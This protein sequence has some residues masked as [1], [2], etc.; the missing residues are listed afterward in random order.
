MIYTGGDIDDLKASRELIE[1]IYTH[2]PKCTFDFVMITDKHATP[3]DVLVAPFS[4]RKTPCTRSAKC[5]AQPAALSLGVTATMK[6]T[7]RL[8]KSKSGFAD[9]SFLRTGQFRR[10]LMQL[11]RK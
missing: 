11:T 5:A 10:L 6:L 2:V 3:M 7:E 4:G 9:P 1:Q 8:N